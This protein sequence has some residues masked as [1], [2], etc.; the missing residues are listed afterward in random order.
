MNKRYKEINESGFCV[1]EIE[2]S[3]GNGRVYYLINLKYRAI[4]KKDFDEFDIGYETY[5]IIKDISSSNIKDIAYSVP[6]YDVTNITSDYKFNTEYSLI[7]L[8]LSA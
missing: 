7:K 5:D 2:D 4:V 8:R 1:I 6:Y 3:N